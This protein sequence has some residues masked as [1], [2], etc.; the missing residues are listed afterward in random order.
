MGGMLGARR[1]SH[2]VMTGLQTSNPHCHP[3]M[4][5]LLSKT[6]IHTWAAAKQTE[7]QVIGERTSKYVR[8]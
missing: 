2:P 1:V 8:Q 7:H 3:K 6:M 4:A 5:L